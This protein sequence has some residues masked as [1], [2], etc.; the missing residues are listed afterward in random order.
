MDMAAGKQSSWAVP[1]QLGALPIGT[2]ATG[3]AACGISAFA[4]QGTNAHAL[5]TAPTPHGTAGFSGAAIR[6]PCA[7]WLQQRFW[8]APRTHAAL[9]RAAA[10][11]GS[12]Q[13]AMHVSLA[14][15][16]LSYV[17]DHQVT[18]K[19]LFPGAGF[20]ELAAAAAKAV[21]ATDS[22]ALTGISIPSPLV[23][24]A[25]YSGS[26][27]Q[28]MPAVMCMLDASSGAVDISSAQGRSVHLKASLVAVGHKLVVESSALLQGHAAL[29]LRRAI[30]ASAGGPA[31]PAY[32][33]GIDDSAE[34]ARDVLLSPAVMDCCLHFGALPAAAAKQL[35]VP[36]GIQALLLPGPAGTR[37]KSS[38]GYAAI[39]RQVSSSQTASVIDYSLQAP[40]GSAA[41]SIT[42]LL[43]K[44]LSTASQAV[45]AMPAAS[46]QASTGMLYETQWSAQ[47][48]AEALGQALKYL[49]N[50]VFLSTAAALDAAALCSVGMSAFQAAAVEQQSALHLE[51][52]AALPQ[53]GTI[54]S[55][56]SPDG[57]LLWGMLRS[58]ALEQTSTR[59]SASDSDS[60]TAAPATQAAGSGAKLQLSATAG[61]AGSDA[62]GNSSRGGV[63][64]AATLVPA[65]SPAGPAKPTAGP[66][67]AIKAARSRVAVTGGMG[68]LGSVLASWAE[69][70]KVAAELVLIGRTGRLAGAD[71]AGSL[72][73]LLSRSTT[74]LTLVMADMAGSEGSSSVLCGTPAS[75]TPLA[76]LFHSGGVLVDS[77]LAKQMPSGIRAVFA[78]KVAAANRWRTSL[79]SQPAAAQV[80]F[81]S[82]AALLGSG[83]QTNYSAANALLD[84]TAGLQQ[85]QVRL[86]SGG[87]LT[88]VQLHW[89]NCLM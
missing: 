20:F 39:A 46:Q 54:G 72:T 67:A 18:G 1:R 23:L 53:L 76:A 78:A 52:M 6:K 63:S 28:A 26:A 43:A 48:P 74:A 3:P 47:E 10:T 64:Y 13:V 73:A 56:K 88:A 21:G 65:A 71:A 77:T 17:W 50:P 62:Y 51:T 25:L 55:S 29:A 11:P 81:S 37:H 89:L 45:A 9:V 19:A 22:S 36:A 75:G 86:K 61:A 2:A 84:A 70:D 31:E 44:P 83:G 40:S 82:V 12:R 49:G 24:P 68:S 7:N 14:A 85:E 4:F 38:A 33:A 66:L 60:L 41:C 79:L 27:K 30:G 5:L 80:L 16:A 58:L 8:V 69:E 42:G 57:S 34:L 15:P 35:K 59:A 32:V 87:S